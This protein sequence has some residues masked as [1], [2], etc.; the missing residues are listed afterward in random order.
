VGSPYNSVLRGDNRN[1]IDAQ[2]GIDRINFGS[3]EGEV[4][5]WVRNLTDSHDFVRAVDF[6]ALGF[7]GG[8]F[9][10]P[11]TFGVTVS[12]KF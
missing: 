4:R 2:L 11:R 5:L 1:I 9:A 7:A 12:A 6:G 10:D 8:Y 3:A